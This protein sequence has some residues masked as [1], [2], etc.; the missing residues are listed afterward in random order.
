MGSREMCRDTSRDMSVATFRDLQLV[1]DVWRVTALCVMS[2]VCVLQYLYRVHTAKI[3][4]TPLR[5][6]P[7][8]RGTRTC[9]TKSRDGQQS[10]C[11]KLDGYLSL[12]PGRTC[13]L[14]F[15][16]L[17]ATDNFVFQS[18]CWVQQYG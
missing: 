17:L 8:V 15:A 3:R 7:H 6:A 16:A 4:R 12:T 14:N 5:R 10:H 18:K 13:W 2:H 11:Y 9:A 1:V